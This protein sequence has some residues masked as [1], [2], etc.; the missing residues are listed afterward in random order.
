MSHNSFD[1]I[2][3]VSHAVR[4]VVAERRY[5]FAAAV[6]PFAAT[7][8]A[9][10]LNVFFVKGYDDILLF[11]VML[12]LGEAAMDGWFM[13][14]QTRLILLGERLEQ[15][16]PDPAAQRLRHNDMRAAVLTWMLFKLWLAVVMMYLIW[17][18]SMKEQGQ[19]GMEFYTMGALFLIGAWLWSLRLGVAHILVGVGYPVKQYLFRVNGLMGSLRL[20]GLAI[21]VS[22]PFQLMS[23][24][25]K[26]HLLMTKDGGTLETV[27]AMA[28]LAAINTGLL[29]FLNAAGVF[30]M[31]D[32]L[33]RP[34]RAGGLR[35]I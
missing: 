35:K 13:F 6:F 34:Q 2:S 9:G 27:F 5:M 1:I 29:V 15:P 17:V 20:L 31:K 30:A 19:G 25:L 11:A 14:L 18:L 21:V 24:P 22:F 16:N 26:E 8:A 32:M 3:A 23:L 12:M 7:L 10:L 4:F 33:G 28:A